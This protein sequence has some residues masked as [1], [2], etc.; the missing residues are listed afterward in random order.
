MSSIDWL[1]IRSWRLNTV[2]LGRHSWQA[3]ALAWL[4][5]VYVFKRLNI[6]VMFPN[7][8]L[9]S[10]VARYV[11]SINY[12]PFGTGQWYS[13]KVEAKEAFFNAEF[14]VSCRFLFNAF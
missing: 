5:T 13:E 1:E 8:D 3:S 14:L 10:F 2:G 6:Y 11:W 12:K 7:F 4:L 9:M